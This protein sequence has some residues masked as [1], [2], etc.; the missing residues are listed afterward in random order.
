[1]KLEGYAKILLGKQTLQTVMELTDLNRNMAI[2]KIHELRKK[3]YLRTSGGGK[4]LRIYDISQVPKKDFGNPVLY[5]TINKYSSIKLAILYEHRVH[6]KELTI[7]EAL[8]EAVKSRIFRI[9]LASLALFQ[10][11]KDWSNL[12]RLAKKN[13][14]R[15][16][17]G[18]LYDIARKTF[19][20][21]RM[22]KKTR[23]ALLKSAK[24]KIQIIKNLKSKDFLEIQKLWKT[25]VPFNKSDL[26][27]YKE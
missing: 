1:M 8:V 9:I 3:S 24:I 15:Q 5:E 17:M 21:K 27:R 25:D 20:V 7:E 23:N 19:R 13:N 12:Y 10:H 2:K 11:I 26:L 22:S 4:Q 16:Q 14:I 6:G 18:A